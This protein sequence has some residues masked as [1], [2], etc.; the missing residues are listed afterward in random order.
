V[1][2]KLFTSSHLTWSTSHTIHLRLLLAAFTCIIRIT[3]NYMTWPTSA[4][5]TE[6]KL[7]GLHTWRIVRSAASRVIN[8]NTI[9]LTLILNLTPTL[10]L[11]LTVTLTVTWQSRPFLSVLWYKKS[12]AITVINKFRWL[13]VCVGIPKVKKLLHVHLTNG[14]MKSDSHRPIWSDIKLCVGCLLLFTLNI[15]LSQ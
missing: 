13:P 6:R 4:E 15:C 10:T 7:H 1:P 2:C 3:A 14:S 8:P 12:P 11:T 9:T 5:K